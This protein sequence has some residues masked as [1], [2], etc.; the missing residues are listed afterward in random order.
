MRVY[1]RVVLSFLVAK[2]CREMRLAAM[3]EKKSK[4]PGGGVKTMEKIEPSFLKC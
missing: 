1:S 2:A 3:E 4:F